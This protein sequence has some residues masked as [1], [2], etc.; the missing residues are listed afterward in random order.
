[1]NRFW[2]IGLIAPMIELA[3]ASG[4]MSQRFAQLAP[5]A[6]VRP[7][8]VSVARGFALEDTALIDGASRLACALQP[9]R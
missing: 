1:M 8:E 4:W 3:A 5:A 2:L 7:C 6:E 9:R